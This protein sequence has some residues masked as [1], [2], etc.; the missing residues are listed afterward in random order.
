MDII[1]TDKTDILLRK[2]CEIVDWK[3]YDTSGEFIQDVNCQYDSLDIALF[4]NKAVRVE[5]DFQKKE[6]Y[7]LEKGELIE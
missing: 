5:V 3:L 6:A 4:D 7:I 2:G 1:D